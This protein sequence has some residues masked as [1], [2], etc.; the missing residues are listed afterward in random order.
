MIKKV[1]MY[2]VVC[3]NCG[4]DVC[5]GEEYSAWNDSDYAREIATESGWHETDDDKH[6]CPDC[7]TFDDNDNLILRQITP[8]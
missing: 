1:E 5:E 4:K 6:Y 3:D 8:K 2:T 7:F